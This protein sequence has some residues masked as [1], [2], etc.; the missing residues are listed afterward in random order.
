[1]CADIFFTI[2]AATVFHAMFLFFF[3]ASNWLFAYFFCMHRQEVRDKRIQQLECDNYNEEQETAVD[4]DAY[5]ESDVS[6]VFAST[7]IYAYMYLCLYLCLFTCMCRHIC[8]CICAG[9]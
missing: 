9:Q 1:M 6:C 7:R 4:D 5:V 3:D 8:I 2:M